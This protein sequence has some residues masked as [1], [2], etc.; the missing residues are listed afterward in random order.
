MFL[1][2]L[3]SGYNMLLPPGL[4][5]LILFLLAWWLRKR[6]R[7]AAIIL[8]ATTFILYA[9]STDIVS[10]LLMRSLESRF[11][12][13]TALNGDVLI[14]L[15]GGATLD[16][17]D[18]D[19]RGNLSGSS[20]NR[21]VTA[22]RLYKKTGLPIIMSSGRVFANTGNEGQIAK[23][24]MVSL[25][26]PEDKIYLDDTSRT[27][28]ENAVNSKKIL[29][30]QHFTHPILVTS[31]FHM[32]RA[33]DDFSKV[34]VAVLP[35]PC[36]YKVSMAQPLYLFRFVPTAGGLNNTGVA[37]KEYLGILALMHGLSEALRN[38]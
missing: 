38:A 2:I 37:L 10:S 13:P 5:I 22:V 29:E 15:G 11:N 18:V 23:R 21:V 30:A 25:G 19:G 33:V 16:T 8:L 3:K 1:D 6:E 31:A 17:P 28:T 12:P 24:V 9:C 26:V 27:T 4:F 35:Y 7:T 20:M 34:G 14:V 36:D 32:A